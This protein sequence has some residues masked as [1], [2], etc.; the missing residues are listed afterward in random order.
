MAWGLGIGTAD[1]LVRPT[2]VARFGA[3]GR[4]ARGFA[5]QRTRTSAV[6][7]IALFALSLTACGP[8]LGGLEKGE[9]GRVVRAYNGDTLELESGQRVFLAEI[10]T[11]RGEDAYAAQAQGELEA[12]ALHREVQLA[13]GGARRWVGRPRE[14][15]S[16]APEAAIAH[17]F[18]KSEGGRWFW[19]QHELVAKGAAYVR[20]RRDNHARAEDLRAIEARARAAERGLWGRREYRPLTV[21]RAADAALAANVNCLSG[22]AP[23]RVLEGRVREARVFE[24]RA[25][26]EME[27]ARETAPFALVVFGESF[28][29]WDGAPLA[30]LTGAR[31]RARGPLGV[32]R[33]QPQLCLD[34]ASQLEVLDGS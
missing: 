9:T 11:P 31:V 3:C 19:L 24:R 1:L 32:Y 21:R 2:R 8:Q 4:R 17:V 28:T 22:A 25:S 18:V 7:L 5:A 33:G 23:Y 10:D 34:H 20:P 27:G 15:Q 13:Y 6:P 26:L 12:L 16:A 30:S 29:A 14:G